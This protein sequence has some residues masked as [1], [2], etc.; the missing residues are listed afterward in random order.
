VLLGSGVSI[1]SGAWRGGGCRPSGNVRGSLSLLLKAYAY[2]Q[3]N[4]R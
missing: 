4:N 2:L 1:N 3:L